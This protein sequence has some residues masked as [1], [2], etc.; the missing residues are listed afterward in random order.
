MTLYLA[1]TSPRRRYLLRRLRLNPRFLKPDF[2]EPAA[3]G[4]APEDYALHCA[5][6]KAASCL[7]RVA[8]GLIVG[9]DTVVAVGHRILGKPLDRS[10]AR[11]I[12]SLLSGR[13]HRVISGLSIIDVADERVISGLEV[14]RVSFRHLAMSEIEDYVRCSEPYDK[15]GAYAIQGRARLFVRRINGCYLNVV[16]LPVPLLLR[17]LSRAGW[18]RQR[19][20]VRSG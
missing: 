10:H 17:M 14:T 18:Q 11:R 15:A 12:L 2:T 4:S 8:A 3:A 19:L 5:R 13:T 6:A 16:G 20:R 1:S 7:G 9:V